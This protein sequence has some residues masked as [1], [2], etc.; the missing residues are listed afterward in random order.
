MAAAVQPGSVVSKRVLGFVTHP[1]A[2]SLPNFALV[3]PLAARP[4][5]AAA[6]PAVRSPPIWSAR[7][8]QTGGVQQLGLRLP[9]VAQRAGAAQLGR[10]LLC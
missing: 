3:P 8:L 6:A 4:G 7:A 2:R 9:A 5:P 10:I 1:A